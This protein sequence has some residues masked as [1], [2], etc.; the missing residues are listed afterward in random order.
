MGKKTF[1]EDLL[2]REDLTLRDG[3]R[4]MDGD[5]LFGIIEDD[6]INTF[7]ADIG[8]IPLDEVESIHYD[9][10]GRVLNVYSE[11][12]GKIYSIGPAPGD[13][14]E[15]NLYEMPQCTLDLDDAFASIF[16]NYRDYLYY[17]ELRERDMIDMAMLGCPSEGVVP[18]SDRVVKMYHRFFQKRLRAS[19]YVGRRFPVNLVMDEVLDIRIG[20]NRRNPFREW[21][22]SQKWDGKPRLR[23]AIID[24]FGATAP[25]LRGPDGKPTAEER[26]YLQSVTEAWFLGAITR[27]Y[28]PTQHDVVP[29]FIGIQGGG[30]GTGLRFLAGADE[31]YAAT[32]ADV[33]NPEKFLESVRGAI[34]VEMG[35]SKQ[36]RGRG[37]QEDLK[38]FISQREDRIRKKYARYEETYPRHF[39]LAA[40]ANNDSLFEDPTGARRF[41]PVY[42]NPDCATKQIP[43]RYRRADLQREVEQIWAEALQM[44]RDG[45]KCYV[46]RDVDELARVMQK[47]AAVENPMAESIEDWLSD[48]IN[49]YTKIGAKI[50]REVIMEEVFGV[51]PRCPSPQADRAWRDWVDSD[52]RWMKCKPF[53]ANGKTRRG[54]ERV[55]EAEEKVRVKT[56]LLVDGDE[57]IP[58]EETPVKTDKKWDDD[59]RFDDD[60]TEQDEMKEEKTEETE[61]TEQSEEETTEYTIDDYKALLRKYEEMLGVKMPME[62]IF[63]EEKDKT[64]ETLPKQNKTVEDEGDD[65]RVV[66]G[67]PKLFSKIVKGYP[68]RVVDE[69]MARDAEKKAQTGKAPIE[70]FRRWAQSAGLREDDRIDVTMLP[71]AA[72]ATLIENGY[73]YVQGKPSAP[74]FRIGVLE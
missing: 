43:V 23:N 24:Y 8:A 69:T 10:E 74:I 2:D 42:C 9:F 12:G 19:G 53:Y 67:V 38:A 35:E 52:K 64:D 17:D 68:T 13:E 14:T 22:E 18:I 57:P 39:I 40:T 21:V 15:V 61:E 1:I 72:V 56:L 36:L 26:H 16:P 48:P 66:D 73:I 51:D 55:L 59:D 4:I 25:A 29:V 45:H 5:H 62:E 34:I 20:T 60:L 30:K 27:M 46:P 65:P 11:N 58:G 41:Y 54:F 49:G 70:A 63:P 6:K 37:V 31:W 71:E 44:Y 3:N 28:K 47:D 50:Y 33:S 7:S 32:T